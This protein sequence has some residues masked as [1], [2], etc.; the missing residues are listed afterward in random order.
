MRYEV[1]EINSNVR[2]VTATRKQI[3]IHLSGEVNYPR[4]HLLLYVPKRLHRP[5]PTFL[6]PN[7]FGNHTIS[8]DVDISMYPQWPCAKIGLN[9]DELEQGQQLRPDENTRGKDRLQSWPLEQI[10]ARGYAIATFAPRCDIEPDYPEGWKWGIRGWFLKQ[11]GRNE[12]AHDEWGAISAWAWSLSRALDYLRTDGDIDAKRVA[13]V[14]FSRLGEAALWAG[15][16]DERFA[17]VIANEGNAG[18][19]RLRPDLVATMTDRSEYWW[20]HCLN[21][22]H[23][24]GRENEMPIDRH[25]LLALIAPRPLYLANA[26]QGLV[27]LRYA[28][29]IA[30]KKAE[31]VYSLFGKIG[32]EVNGMPSL[33]TSVGDFIGYHIRTGGHRMTDYDWEQ[34]L[35]FADR[36]FVKS[37]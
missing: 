3:T 33:N 25:E 18:L 12:I 24:V 8:S 30:A 7:F 16:Q 17:M 10:L 11:T 13:V 27:S 35:S 23:Y 2:S 15:A 14:G 4:I 36:H 21:L 9:N 28:E 26:D 29:F 31:P 22:E 6:V 1:A 37:R 5:V 32:L 20:W 19:M 34:F